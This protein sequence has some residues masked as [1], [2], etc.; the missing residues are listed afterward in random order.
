MGN[1]LEPTTTVPSAAP[2]IGSGGEVLVGRRAE[3][4]DGQRVFLEVGGV[5][6]GVLE[7]AGRLHAFENRCSHQG[8]PVCEGTVIGRV[9]QRFDAEG[10][11]VGYEFSP[12]E[13]HLVCP[14]HGVEF[15]LE[16]GVC[17]SDRRRRIRRFEVLERD[18]AVYVVL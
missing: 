1:P 5:Q 18:G 4:E 16:T 13:L 7:H 6:I 8:G 11:T 10:R 17:A 14:W 15:E 12:T 2:A 3:L 9:R